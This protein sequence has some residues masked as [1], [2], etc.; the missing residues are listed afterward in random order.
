MASTVIWVARYRSW[1]RSVIVSRDWN[2]FWNRFGLLSTFQILWSMLVEVLESII[3]VIKVPVSISGRPIW[4]VHGRTG[5]HRVNDI[6]SELK[7]KKENE[8][9][10]ISDYVAEF[11]AV[12]SDT[13]LILEPGR[14]LIANCAILVADV[15]GVKALVRPRLN[16]FWPV[17][18][19]LRVVQ[20]KTIL[21][22]KSTSEKVG[23][24]ILNDEFLDRL[25]ND[26][27]WPPSDDVVWF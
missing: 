2:L 10:S 23:S 12:D 7:S 5:H 6:D 20:R 27:K 9:P 18:D 21:F 1:N 22:S 19:N 11:N 15:I 3:T 4:T 25:Q 8:Y 26:W 24:D 14:S 16:S 17:I 13:R